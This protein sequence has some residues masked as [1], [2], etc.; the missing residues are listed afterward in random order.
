VKKTN[1]NG[2]FV[3]TP[4]ALKRV[5]EEKNNA[6]EVFE[7]PIITSLSLL[8]K[9]FKE[10]KNLL[11]VETEWKSEPVFKGEIKENSFS[12]GKMNYHTIYPENFFKIFDE[13]E[14][15][16][17]TDLPTKLINLKG[18]SD[19]L[20]IKETDVIKVNDE[21]KKGIEIKNYAALSY[22]WDVAPWGKFKKFSKGFNE[23]LHAGSKKSLRK[24][25]KACKEKVGVDYL[26]MDCLCIDQNNEDELTRELSQTRKHYSNAKVTLVAIQAD[27]E[28]VGTDI[29]KRLGSGG[30]NLEDVFSATSD[31][32]WEAIVKS[33]WFNRSWTLQE[34]LLSPQ[35]V[36][37]FDDY[38]IDGRLLA[39]T[40]A[41]KK[42]PS[43]LSTLTEEGGLD[44]FLK[45]YSKK[46]VTPLGWS[47]YHDGYNSND[48]VYL[49]LFQALEAIKNRKRYFVI[50]GI[51]SV[52]G[53]LPYQVEPNYFGDKDYNYTN[54][55]MANELVGIM[56]TAVQNGYGEPFSWYGESNNLTGFCW[57]PKILLGGKDTDKNGSMAIEGLIKNVGCD[58]N[59]IN[60]SKEGIV[61]KGSKYEIID[62]EDIS[63]GENDKLFS[64]KIR[65]KNENNSNKI[66]LQGTHKTLKKIE[67]GNDGESNIMLLLPS[68]NQWKSNPP[69]A[70]LVE[71]T[72]ENVYHRV[73]L[74][75]II[76]GL[77]NL[78][79]PE[80]NLT[81]GMK[82]PTNISEETQNLQEI[83]SYI[84]IPPK[85]Q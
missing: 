24:A 51:Y 45:N 44:D 36:F 76:E 56:K 55:N 68:I 75:R 29:L 50:D 19:N 35:T 31:I 59:S 85:K 22:S 8:N 3:P 77:K 9:D 1:I 58:P 71:K 62:T 60:F 48:V 84:E 7:L 34:G 53:L 42:K 73:D 13:R 74:I 70:L 26:W 25:I 65:A 66:T 18:I 30:E 82:N 20:K 33:E 43:N 6:K 57:L 69:I 27:L 80:E 37:M 64:R 32:I 67:I 78:N 21:S 2:A 46:V 23:L 28:K 83:C 40:W 41:I 15:N 16:S 72:G 61:I 5:L 12:E 81:I 4:I 39:M 52:T 63:G 47:Y 79:N 54:E 10:K 38:L 14:V 49:S 17:T 11:R